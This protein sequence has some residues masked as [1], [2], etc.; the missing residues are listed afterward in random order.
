MQRHVVAVEDGGDVVA[1]VVDDDVGAEALD[2]LGV[3][4]ARRG[5]D[6]R[7]E[8]LGELDGDGADAARPGLDED[9]LT[10]LD[11]GDL[12]ERLPRREPDERERRRLDHRRGGWLGG[13]VVLVERDELGERAG[14]PLG[15]GVHLVADREPGDRRPD[16]GH[17]ASDVVAQ[18]QRHVLTEEQLELAA[19]GP[20]VERD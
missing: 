14:G 2:E 4:D 8:V 9:P 13:D 5:G 6:E 17:D 15:A 10:G 1:A 19:A 7:A 3:G 12:D 11:R 20:H 18:D 16:G